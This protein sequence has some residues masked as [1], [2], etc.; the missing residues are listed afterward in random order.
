MDK[1]ERCGELSLEEFLTEFGVPGKPCILTEATKGWAALEWTPE[2]LASRFGEEWVDITPS[3]SLEE[4]TLEMTLAEY[5]DY[6][7]SPDERLLYLTSWNFREFCPELMEDFQVPI[8]FREDWLQ[9]IE[10]EQQFDMMWLFLG[11]AHAGFRL[12]VDIG[13]TSAWNVQLTG[14]KKWILFPP[15][16][17]EFL[18]G[19]EVDAFDP[20][21]EEFPLFAQAKK[22][23]CIV[24]AGELIF[25]PSGWWHQT[26]NLETGL[27]I[28]ANY[29][30]ETNCHK[31]LNWL[32]TVG[33]NIEVGHDMGEFA[34]EFERVMNRHLQ[35]S[36]P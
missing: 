4:A 26:K 27:A 6:L 19:G 23:E 32:N 11:P 2:D 5:V 30:N 28:T 29:A 9:E 22:Y 16:Q 14:S 17:E 33:Q 13:Q 25:T 20:N 24:K 7:K 31:V 34:R 12:H 10:E 18:Y 36:K 1:I 8:Y 15:E 3:A 35:E 21:L